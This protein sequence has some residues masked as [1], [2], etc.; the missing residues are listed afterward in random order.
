MHGDEQEVLVLGQPDDAGANERATREV[1]GMRELG[2][3]KPV[4]GRFL[5]CCRQFVQIV[6]CERHRELRR[7]DLDLPAAGNA[8]RRAQNL[9]APHNFVEAAFQKRRI[10][11]RRHP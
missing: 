3:D 7:N 10:E 2:L 1:E 8:D 4:R 5:F 11:R 6:D 9:V